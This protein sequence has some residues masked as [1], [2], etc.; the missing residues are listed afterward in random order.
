MS[1]EGISVPERCR[2][3]G[4]R[5]FPSSHTSCAGFLR[6]WLDLKTLA[7]VW[8]VFRWVVPHPLAFSCIIINIIILR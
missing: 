3:C 4:Q 6:R 2:R 5:D 1:L 7:L 8:T